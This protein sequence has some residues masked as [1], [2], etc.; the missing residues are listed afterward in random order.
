MRCLKGDSNTSTKLVRQAV[1]SL[2]VLR[3]HRLHRPNRVSESLIILLAISLVLVSGQIPSNLAALTPPTGAYFDHLVVIMMENEGINQICGRNPPPCNGS[4]SPY[5]SS[6]ANSYGISRQYLSLIITSWPN[7]YG[8]L[9]AFIPSGCS[10]TNQNP[11]YPPA[12]SLTSPNLADRF[13][14]AG[15]SWKGYME[16]Q[17]VATGCATE[18]H[19]PYTHEHNGFVAFQ[20]ITNN[21]SRCNKIVLANPTTCGAVRDCALINDLNSPS[22][23]NFMWLTPNDCNDMR[24]WSGCSNG[25]T[26]GGTSTCVRDGDNYLGSLVPNILNSNTFTTTRAALFITFDEGEGYCPLN[27]STEDCLYAVWAGPVAKTGFASSQLYNQYSLTKTIEVNWNLLSLTSNDAAAVPMSEFFN[28]PPLSADFST[29]PSDPAPLQTI[30]F[31]A[32]ATGGIQPYSYQWEFGDG[33]VGAGNPATHSY[34]TNSTY[35]VKLTV[36]T[37]ASETASVVHAVTVAAH[38]TGMTVTCPSSGTLGVAFQCSATVTDTSAAPVTPIGNVTFSPGGPCTLG[39]PTANSSSCSVSVTSST[40]GLVIVRGSYPGDASHLASGGN[41]S[42]TVNKRATSVTVVCSP[43]PVQNNTTTNCSANVVDVDAGTVLTPGG[44]VAFATNSTG[45]FN[46]PSCT[47]ASTA[48][49][50]TASCSVAY[51]PNMIGHHG[52]T[53]QYGGDTSHMANS[54]ETVET[55]APAPLTTRF[56]IS[57]GSSIPGQPVNF[58]ATASGGTGPYSYNWTFGDGS[59]ATGQTLIH[60]FSTSGSYNVTLTVLDSSMRTSTSSSVF[61]VFDPSVGS[62]GGGGWGHPKLV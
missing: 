15:V 30:Q 53:L 2:N 36:H 48:T 54:A 32:S 45:Y 24:A 35:N 3:H 16:S 57:P 31:T 4:N 56:T 55:V 26:S 10:I 11:C 13:E 52:I 51:T 5:M 43:N 44:S 38:S 12:G 49:T 18:T 8:I 29:T 60:S 40:V 58:T 6:L 21:T 22:A 17:A 20:D 46:V 27:N 50:G 59:S 1:Q 39:E 62:G 7:Y 9:G 28:I 47:L 19:E 14:A 34:S 41:A 61:I 23:P 37:S 25:C 42:V 33:T